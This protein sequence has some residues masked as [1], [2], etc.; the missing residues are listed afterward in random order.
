MDLKV[1]DRPK[2]LKYIYDDATHKPIEGIKVGTHLKKDGSIKFETETDE[3]GRFKL[4]AK[5]RYFVP[6]QP[7]NMAAISYQPFNILH[8]K[9][10]GFIFSGKDYKNDLLENAHGLFSHMDTLFIKQIPISD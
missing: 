2:M 7:P 3:N 8:L 1:Q 6:L 4:R 5:N 10:E 9:K